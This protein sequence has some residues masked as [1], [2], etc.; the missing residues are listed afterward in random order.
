MRAGYSGSQRFGLI[1]WSGDVNRSW[2][3]LKPQPEIA[4]Q[5]GMQ[6]LAYYH[7]DLGGFA[8]ANLDDEL[9]T[10][11][12]QYGV[13][14][15][16]FR[17]HAQEEVPSE[18]VFRSEKVKALAKRSIE[19][20]YKFLPYNYTLAF[21]N[22][23][24]GTP[25]MRPLFFNEPHRKILQDHAQSYLWGN[26]VLVSPVTSSKVEEQIVYFPKES[27]WFDFYTDTQYKGG[28]LS[29]YKLSEDHIPT[30]IRSGAFIPLA[31][32]MQSTEEY[33]PGQLV[34]HYYQDHSITNSQGN[35]YNDDGITPN[36]FEKG[37]YELLTFISNWTGDN[38][39]ITFTAETGTQ[40]QTSNKKIQLIV[41]NVL[42]QPDAIEVDGKRAQINWD[43]SAGRLSIPV[44]WN[45]AAK[46]K[47]NIKLKE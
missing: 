21:E 4:L 22:N 19:L 35:L 28:E 33:D 7:S 46:A 38:L 36:T 40:Y 29:I 39:G 27:N 24:H 26:D 42:N 31:K 23:Q 45:T 5:M 17:P 43:K 11:W 15:P 8:G 25:L 18:P 32:A 37:A 16:V 41:H 34:I 44:N 30:F 1:P 9:Y 3:G 12:L 13:F 10:R 2:G 47:I 20:R 6:G 14:Q